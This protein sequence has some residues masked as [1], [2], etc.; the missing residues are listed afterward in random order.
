MSR[1]SESNPPRMFY[2]F[3]DLQAMLGVK[4]HTLYRWIKDRKFPRPVKL[5]E[6]TVA[7]R[8]ADIQAWHDALPE[9]EA[10]AYGR[11]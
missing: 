9:A 5:G 7:W 8:A 1:A 6:N 4:R 3:A 10:E 2:R 11:S